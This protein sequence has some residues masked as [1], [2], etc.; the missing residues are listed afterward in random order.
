M[1]SLTLFLSSCTIDW[2]NEKDKEVN[3]K[4]NTSKIKEE[5]KITI[6]LW[7][8]KSVTFWKDSYTGLF[9]L[10]WKWL[11]YNQTW[12]ILLLNSDWWGYDI[13][14]IDVVKEN[15]EILED[16]PPEWI[17][18]TKFG[19][20]LMTINNNS[21]ISESDFFP[22]ST[23]DTKVQLLY[24]K[25]EIQTYFLFENSY[26]SCG[27]LYTLVH[28][29]KSGK[30]LHRAYFK[31]GDWSLEKEKWT[32]DKELSH[33]FNE[34]YACCSEYIGNCNKEKTY[35][36]SGKKEFIK[37]QFNKNT[38]LSQIEE[39]LESIVERNINNNPI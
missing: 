7:E 22:F 19:R 11:W 31:F 16:W 17:D 34:N 25:P 39:E 5:A 33:L 36:N 12:T 27:N 4:A 13:Y 38:F 32:L 2:N 1:K 29:K 18:L 23:T 8:S 24:K 21:T 37:N 35:T 26:Q 3:A 14:D 6:G 30:F 28:Y 10:N 9:P 15:P 20:L